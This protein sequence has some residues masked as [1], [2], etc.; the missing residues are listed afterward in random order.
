[1]LSRLRSI[2]RRL[3]PGRAAE[4]R[5][6]SVYQRPEIL[7]LHA[8][9]TTTAGVHL[10]QEP[11]V[12]LAPTASSEQVGSALLEVLAACRTGVPHPS[13]E[14]WR[15]ATKPLLAAAQFRSWRALER[16]AKACWVT[17]KPTARLSFQS[18]PK[19]VQVVKRAGFTSLA[20]DDSGLQLLPLPKR[21]GQR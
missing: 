9:A 16:G 21:L 8:S 5:H 12:R 10:A 6:A 15:E 3:R 7:L 11:I 18:W 17:Q 1:M 14:E 20:Q 2:G 19:A 4:L 13:P